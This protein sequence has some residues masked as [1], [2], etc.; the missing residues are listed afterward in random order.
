MNILIKNGTIITSKESFNSDIYISE[1]KIV[2][3]G[4]SL[5]ILEPIDKTIDASGKLIIPGGID[6]HVH[7]HLP[8]PAGFSTDD[9]ES[10]SGD[11][12]QNILLR[13]ISSDPGEFLRRRFKYQQKKYHPELEEMKENW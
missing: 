3:L 8:T 4:E 1:G 9:F 5:N 12:P 2:Q 13:E 6:P 11:T 10:G 7:M